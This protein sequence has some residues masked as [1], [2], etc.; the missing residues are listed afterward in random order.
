MAEENSYLIN[1]TQMAK[2]NKF[3]PLIGREKELERLIHILLRASKNNPAVVGASGIGKSA[4]LKGLISFM[5]SESAPEYMQSREV[6]GLDVAKIMLDA[7]DEKEYAD[8]VK[9]AM[10]V[11]IDSNKQKLL[12]LNDISF[13]VY[14]DTNPENKE[15][16]KFL[17]L[18]LTSDKVN[19]MLE[20]DTLHYVGF[21][22]KDTAVMSHIQS[23]L[24]EEPTLEES[25][26]I[27]NARKGTLEGHY[28]II[29]PPESVKV[30]C[31]LTGRYVKQRSFLK[32]R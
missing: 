26:E 15:P 14:V 23:L 13:L 6:V 16:A 24:L 27:C 4:L 9:S 25:I 31:Q 11:V 30:A 19:C 2:E 18:A 5:A 1:Y 12:Y 32:R 21:L 8:L 28:S 10:Q 7:K 20:T 22:E 3:P 17:K 29:I